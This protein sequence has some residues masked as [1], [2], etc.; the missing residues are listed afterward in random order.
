MA[1]VTATYQ[2][3]GSVVG[4]LKE[5][6]VKSYLSERPKEAPKTDDF[7]VVDFPVMIRRPFVGNDDFR[8]RTQGVIYLFCRSKNDG[9]PNIDRQTRLVRKVFEMFPYKDDM[10]ECVSPSVLT[11]GSD[12]YGFQVTTITFTIRTRINS[13]TNIQ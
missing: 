5:C 11:R 7:A 13:I 8:Y 9:T 6:G 3:F 10:C 12:E 4:M 2:M 1:N